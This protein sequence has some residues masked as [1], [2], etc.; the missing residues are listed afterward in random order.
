MCRVAFPGMVNSCIVQPVSPIIWH[1]PDDMVLARLRMVIHPLE[2]AA[3]HLGASFSRLK[4][5][6]TTYAF[7]P[8]LFNSVNKASDF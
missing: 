5:F 6:S 8:A 7:I 2:I 1:I 3:L 4:A